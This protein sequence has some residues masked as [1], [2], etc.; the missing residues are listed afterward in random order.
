MQ[1]L[2]AYS[3]TPTTRPATKPAKPHPETA[4]QEWWKEEERVVSVP[5]DKFADPVTRLKDEI[6]QPLDQGGHLKT[7]EEVWRALIHR[8]QE[9]VNKDFLSG[10]TEQERQE[11][12]RLGSQIDAEEAPSYERFLRSLEASKDRKKG[13]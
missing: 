9:L 10:L 11:M 1:P 5:V 7:D 12:E 8:Y 6:H 3:Q 13:R 2:L 4:V